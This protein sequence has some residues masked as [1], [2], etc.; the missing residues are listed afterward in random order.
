MTSYSVGLQMNKEF[1]SLIH[2][3]KYHHKTRG[4]FKGGDEFMGGSKSFWLERYNEDPDLNNVP[5]ESFDRTPLNIKGEKS[6]KVCCLKH[7]IIHEF[8]GIE[9]YPVLESAGPDNYYKREL[10]RLNSS[11]YLNIKINDI[12]GSSTKWMALNKES[13]RELI[14]FLIN[15]Y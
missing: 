1:Q 8:L 7:L 2:F 14:I 9:E 10:D 15:L 12:D 13:I 6:E 5:L 4:L 3:N 11:D